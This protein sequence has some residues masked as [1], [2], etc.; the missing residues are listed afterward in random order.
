MRRE[1]RRLAKAGVFVGIAHESST[2]LMQPSSPGPLAFAYDTAQGTLRR[3]FAG[4]RTEQVTASG[5]V[6]LHGFVANRAA[7]PAGDDT[8]DAGLITARWR[9]AG[10]DAAKAIFGDA[11]WIAYDADKRE[12]TAARDRMGMNGV[13]YAQH[14]GEVW[15]ALSL[16]ALLAAWPGRRALNPSA[17]ARHINMQP[18]VEGETHHAGIHALPRGCTLRV[19][20]DQITVQPYWTIQQGPVLKLASDVAYAEAYR[21]VLFQVAREYAPAGRAAITLSSGMD[22]T[23]VAAAL[24]EATPA[25][26]LVAMTWT[27]PEL[28]EAD[29]ITYVR[30]VAA[31]LDLPLQE[32]RGDQHWTMC[33]PEGIRTSAGMPFVLFYDDLWDAGHSAIRDAGATTVFDG[34]SGDAL[35]GANV[36]AYADLLLQGRW[37]RCAREFRAHMRQN[38]SRLTMPQAIKML[39]LGPLLRSYAPA[40]VNRRPAQP[41]KWLLPAHHALW[42][43][44]QQPALA[45]S[46]LPGRRRRFDTIGDPF[47]AQVG[48]HYGGLAQRFGLQ[49]RH[50]LMDHRLVEFALSLPTDQTIRNGQRKTIM[51]NAMRGRLPDSVLDMWGKIYP[52]TMSER[53]LRERETAKIWGYL[54]NMRAAEMGFVDEGIVRGVYQDYLGKKAKDIRFFYAIMLEDWLRR[55]F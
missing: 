51:R 37:L 3:V 15:L 31:K 38:P 41:A 53:G 2:P 22:S 29:E 42:Q 27:T 50:V 43:S 9:Q 12:V 35:F 16:D 47:S 6:A 49:G 25:L 40:L 52:T 48:I 24:R 14:A 36:F 17:I 4:A 26:D 7:L 39:L 11:V 34:F 18:P 10:A 46:G 19:A 55:Y 30:E 8:S 21:E 20:G 28:A 45:G 32:V 5:V 23:S 13:F 54:T 33:H 1:K 44:T